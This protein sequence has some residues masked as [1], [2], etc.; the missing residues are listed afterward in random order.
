MRACRPLADASSAASYGTPMSVSPE[1]F[2][3][4][5]RAAAAKHE[6]VVGVAVNGFYFRLKL[7]AR[8]MTYEVDARYDPA[9]NTWVR[10]DPHMGN[11]IRFVTEEVHRA[12]NQ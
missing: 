9:T 7:K 12:I 6:K 5:V 2:E 3:S 8:R 1:R 11:T 4:L 10:T